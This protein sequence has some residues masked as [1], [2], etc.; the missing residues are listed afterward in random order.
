M[1][2]NLKKVISS[3]AALT[4]SVS[5]VSAFAVSFPDVASDAAYAQ[6]VEEL[7]SLGVVSGFDDGTF[8]PDE[9]VTRAQM[10][11]MIVDALAETNQAEAS[12]STTQFRDVSND[13]WAKGYINQGVADTFISGYGD[14]NFGPE[15][16]V[17]YAQA[18]SMLV[19]AIGY[20]TY[21]EGSGG[22]PNGYK[23]WAASQGITAGISG[24]SDDTQL[25]R[26]QVARLI[27]NAMGAPVCVIKDYETTIDGRRVPNLEIKD[28]EG[29]DYQTLF[30]KKHNAYKVYGRVTA[31]NKT[32]SGIATDQVEFKVEKA[33][34]FDDEY[35]KGT[36]E[37]AYEVINA[38]YGGTE[39]PNM[40]RTYS[41][42]LIQK[43]SDDEWHILSISAAAANKTVTVA[44]EDLDFGKS[45]AN[46]NKL[47]FYPSG[48]TKNSTKYELA[49]EYD[50]Y[51]NGQSVEFNDGYEGLVKYI[52]E[53]ETASVTLQKETNKGTTSTSSKYNLIQI[54]SYKTVIVSDVIVKSDQI[55]INFDEQGSDVH[56]SKMVVYLDDDSYTYDFVDNE[57]NP[58]NPADIQEDDVLSVAYDDLDN[59]YIQNSSFY[60]VFVSRDTAE[61]KCTTMNSD[62]DEFTI[63]GTKYKVAQGM[64]PAIETS[65]EYTLYLD[66]FGRIAKADEDSANKKLGI[67]KNIYKKSGGDWYAQVI[68]KEGVEEEYKIDNKNVETYG[69]ILDSKFTTAYTDGVEYDDGDKVERYPEQVI[70]YSIAASSNKITIKQGGEAL[71]YDYS[72]SDQEYKENGTKIGSLKMAD[73][74]VIIDISD[75]DDDDDIKV[76]SLSSLSDGNEYSAFGYDRT[77]SGDRYCRYVLITN[78][79]S[80]FNSDTPMAVYNGSE[81]VDIEGDERIAFN[82]IVDGEEKQYVLKDTL[83]GDWDG[84]FEE[85]DPLF[86][87][88]NSADEITD[89]EPVFTK[90]GMLNSSNWDTFRQTADDDLEAVLANSDTDG[91]WNNLLRD[92]QSDDMDVL[93]GVV[94]NRS[95]NNITLAKQLV[96]DSGKVGGNYAQYDQDSAK[97]ISIDLT[98]KDAKVYAYDFAANSKYSRVFTDNGLQATPDIKSLKSTTGEGADILDIT[99]D[100]VWN[101]V[102]YAVVRVDDDEV[103]EIYL[104]INED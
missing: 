56:G 36:D 90:S 58:V 101:D 80:N 2:K 9:L 104:I 82:L 41:E 6:A 76:V 48:T 59:G 61:G 89:I 97:E 29:K 39:A 66:H 24:L 68:T 72:V 22:W 103:K 65:N 4:L 31:T 75:A 43:D 84:Y 7:S 50:I 95:G 38:Y 55:T 40:L 30:T 11:K 87:V 63:G 54:S 14:G 51:I 23:T 34:N 16:N 62:G 19:R 79:T 44:A 35:Y 73:S 77:T 71:G 85:G 12:K 60:D 74:T 49:D 17:T 91:Y 18:Q 5:A 83:E 69:K 8:R 10:A 26:A 37:G 13:H 1:N 21:A 57:G 46:E 3:V 92:G 67:L 33:D 70:E 27:D 96:D 28:D 45:E 52:D 32:D 100:D 99:G 15:D 25:T 94:V 93:F 81:L 98:C 78:G 47:Y 86:F 64:A 42:A 102:V 20:Q 88:K 53:N